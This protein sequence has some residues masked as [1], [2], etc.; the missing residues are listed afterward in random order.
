MFW[1]LEIPFKTGF[2]VL[3][4]Y[5]PFSVLRKE[6]L[7][8]QRHKEAIITTW[9]NNMN[10]R[11]LKTADENSLTGSLVINHLEGDEPHENACR[12]EKGNHLT[13]A[14]PRPSVRKKK[15]SLLPFPLAI[16][17]NESVANR[18]L[19]YIGYL[20]GFMNSDMFQ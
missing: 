2:T 12:G 8:H 11:R 10:Q 4:F 14:K 6:S 18:Q 15:T 17:A 1:S 19:H 20:E 3:C 16:T 5:T 13:F 7:Y 9:L